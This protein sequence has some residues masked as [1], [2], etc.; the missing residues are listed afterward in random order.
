MFDWKTRFTT[1]RTIIEETMAVSVNLE[2][3]PGDEF[4][5]IGEFYGSPDGEPF[6]WDSSRKFHV[7][8]RLRYVGSRQDTHSKDHPSAWHVIFEASDGKRYAATQT[9]FVTAEEWQA[10]TRYFARRLLRDSKPEQITV[11]A[12]NI[13]K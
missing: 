13:K 11:Q 6:S 8:E 12:A 7:G 3:E 1:G 4:V 5:C 2:C 10:I 9:Y